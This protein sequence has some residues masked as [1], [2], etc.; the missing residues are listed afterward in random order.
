MKF[1]VKRFLSKCEQSHSFLRICSH[2]LK[3][4]LDGKF[5][6]LCGVPHKTDIYLVFKLPIR[7]EKPEEQDS[8]S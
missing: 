8:K 1:S 7:D 4:I 3:Q 2:L 5:H 6:L